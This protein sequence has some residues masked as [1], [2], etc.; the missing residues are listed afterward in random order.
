MDSVTK[1]PGTLR[2]NDLIWVIVDW[3]TKGAQILATKDND[4][5]EKLTNM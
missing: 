5:L 4:K 3:L 2:D 1:L